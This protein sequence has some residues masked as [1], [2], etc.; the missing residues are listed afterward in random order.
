MSASRLYTWARS[1]VNHFEGRRIS[2]SVKDIISKLYSSFWEP[3]SEAAK[4]HQ[5]GST[6]SQVVIIHMCQSMLIHSPS[7]EPKELSALKPNRNT[8]LPHH[9][10]FQ[11]ASKDK[12]CLRGCVAQKEC[13]ISLMTR[14]SLWC[15]KELPG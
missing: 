9:F 1:S 15:G 2:T 8:S 4:D 7:P 13:S 3:A 12:E 11:F 6:Q 10:N 5:A 14:G